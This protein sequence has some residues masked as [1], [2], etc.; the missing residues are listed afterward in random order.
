MNV[1]LYFEDFTNKKIH[2]R[3]IKIKRISQNGRALIYG[4][5]ID[6]TLW[7]NAINTFEEDCIFYSF[8]KLSKKEINRLYKNKVM[9]EI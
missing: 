9:Q 4:K 8:H 2:R 6:Y 3:T 1:Y 7:I 5:N